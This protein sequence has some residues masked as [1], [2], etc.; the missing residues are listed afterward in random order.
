MGRKITIAELANLPDFGF[1]S[2]AEL[3]AV[4]GCSEDTIDRMSRRGQ[5]PPRVRISPRRWGYP[6]GA[7]KKDLADK[8]AE[9]RRGAS[10]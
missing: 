1:L 6:V 4:Y 3:A 8:L 9:A 5:G 2:R 7:I 10:G